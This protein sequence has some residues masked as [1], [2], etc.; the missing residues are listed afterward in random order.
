M[1]KIILLLC[2]T[3]VA[4]AVMYS[5]SIQY[6]CEVQYTRNS[7]G[8]TAD[9]T[10]KV[11][12]GTPEF[13]YYLTTN[14]PLRGEILMKS[15]STKKTAYTFKGVKPGTYFIKIADQSGDQT[16]KTVIISENEN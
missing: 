3:F 6:E 16:G 12:S 9:I 7:Q 4:T 8:V 13:T 1:K 14:N 11:T 2:L 15:N 5:Q 10:V